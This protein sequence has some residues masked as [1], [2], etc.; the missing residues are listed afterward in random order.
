M[1]L[2]A[3]E[4]LAQLQVSAGAKVSRRRVELTGERAGVE[5]GHRMSPLVIGR[6]VASNLD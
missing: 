6:L 2:S 1:E 4:E 5:I 3:T